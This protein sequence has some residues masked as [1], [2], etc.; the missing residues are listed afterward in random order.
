MN[1][2][3]GSRYDTDSM[4]R[5][6]RLVDPGR[7]PATIR[8]LSVCRMLGVVNGRANFEKIC[9]FEHDASGRL[10]WKGSVH[11]PGFPPD[12]SSLRIPFSFQ[13]I[14][15]RPL[16]AAANGTDGGQPRIDAA[17]T[18]AM[19]PED[20]RGLMEGLEQR[21]RE[22]RVHPNV[23]AAY[24]LIGESEEERLR[25]STALRAHVASEMGVDAQLGIALILSA[26]AG[27]IAI[28]PVSGQSS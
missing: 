26:S 24:T 10:R 12:H 7:L 4:E 16:A 8:A 13:S 21:E 9:A 25:F 22:L 14:A 18:A 5:L 27:D 19:R 23:Q 3:F 11:S 15:R 20:M 2:R 17:A 6:T 1:T 28:L